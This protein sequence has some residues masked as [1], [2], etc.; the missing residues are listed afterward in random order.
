MDRQEQ[1]QQDVNTEEAVP[2]RAV[3]DT[4]SQ[5]PWGNGT[6]IDELDKMQQIRVRTR[7]S[8]Y[9]ITVIDGLHGEI[10]VSGGK[11]L[12]DLTSAQ[13]NGATLGGSVC[14]LRGIY[15]GFKMELVANGERFITS[16]VRAVSIVPIGSHNVQKPKS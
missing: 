14:K 15:P 5:E 11:H 7:N 6:Q 1:S 13:L 9:E 3:L 10:L 16:T 2:Y 8:L 4:W 12:P